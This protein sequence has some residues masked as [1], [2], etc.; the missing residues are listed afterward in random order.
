MCKFVS[1]SQEPGHVNYEEM[2]KYLARCI[3]EKNSSNDRGGRRPEPQ[4]RN[5]NFSNQV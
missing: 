5:N 1:P 4:F 3:G 2:V